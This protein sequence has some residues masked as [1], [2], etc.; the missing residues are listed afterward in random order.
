[1]QPVDWSHSW[2]NEINDC[3]FVPGLRKSPSLFGRVSKHRHYTRKRKR[4]RFD[5]ACDDFQSLSGLSPF[6]RK[7][8]FQLRNPCDCSRLSFRVNAAGTFE[9]ATSNDIT[10]SNGRT[11]KVSMENLRPDIRELVSFQFC[12]PCVIQRFFRFPRFSL[13]S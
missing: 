10:K 8:T 2:S 9:L 3:L 6:A 7:I 5:E 12:L 4:R 13:E 1:M 11:T